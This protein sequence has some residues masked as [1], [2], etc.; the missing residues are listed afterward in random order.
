MRTGEW[1]T[2][3]RQRV[4]R[5]AGL[6]AQRQY[7]VAGHQLDVTA[8]DEVAKPAPAAPEEREEDEE[9]EGPESIVVDEADM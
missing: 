8:R 6:S 4:T 9:E 7:F 2:T 1:V 5:L 3:N